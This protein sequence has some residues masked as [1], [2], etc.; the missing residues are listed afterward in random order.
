M[1]TSRKCQVKKW[2]SF[3][4]RALTIT[5]IF[6]LFHIAVWAQYYPAPKPISPDK[7][8]RLLLLLKNSSPDK[9]RVHLLLSL[10]NLNFNKPL[11][12]K[13]DIDRAM[14]FARDA[15]KLSSTLHDESGYNDAQL[16]IAD[17]FT[18]QDDMNSAENI[19]GLLNDTSKINL[20]LNL[21][22][23]YWLREVKVKDE[24]WKKALVFA[25]QARQ[26][27]VKLHLQEKEILAL[28]DM[29]MIHA[30]QGKA[31]A[32]SEYLEVIKKYKAINYPYL[33]Y[34]YAQLAQLNYYKGKPDKA[35]YY[36]MQTIKSMKSTGDSTVAG[37]FYLLRAIICLNNDE[38]QESYDFSLRAIN[39]YKV[40]AGEYSLA[41]R[42]IF[43]MIPRVLRKMKRYR[44]ALIYI[45]KAM[46]DYPSLTDADEIS[47]ASI[48]G[49]I[50]RDMKAY[51][52]A[53]KYFIQVLELSK[54]TGITSS[55]P[56][57]DI[58]QLYVESGQYEKAKPYLNKVL[59]FSKTEIMPSAALSHLHYM[60]FLT[61]SAT[62][63][64]KSAIQHISRFRGLEE[65]NLRLSK[66]KEVQKLEVEYGTKEK[67]SAIKIKDQNILLLKQSAKLQEAKLSQ[68]NLIKNITII[69]TLSLFVITGLL[70]KQYRNKQKTNK[71]IIQ[72]NE[73]MTQN[74]RVITQKNQVITQKNEQL[75]HLLQEK[76]WLIR[77]VHHRVKNNLH[78]V[79]C[80]LESQAAYLEEDALKAIEKS[81]NR[82]YAM[83]LIHQKL[84][85]SNDIN[86]IDMSSYIPELVQ[87]MKDIF[88]ISDQI[89]FH[90]NID[91]IGLNPSQAIPLAL[92][93]NEALTNSIKYAFPG[94][95][96]GEILISLRDCG[97]FL[98]LVLA[99]NGIGIDKNKEKIG[100][101]SLGLKLMKGLSKEI[102]GDIT[103]KNNHGVKITI[104]FKSDVPDYINNLQ[105]DF[106]TSA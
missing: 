34:V 62:G 11:K 79:I 67:E 78:T 86:T 41:D 65:Y 19:L 5:N 58:G 97:D 63:D 88:D 85:L 76:D 48:I 9:D 66:D 15:S 32:E 35:L 94:K 104:I 6:V 52:K 8:P 24:D 83:S 60:L 1:R 29:A 84:Y 80:L 7:E 73:M 90:M 61:D 81:Q 82:V 31:S 68:T 13:A 36:S 102:K 93:I 100:P 106:M 59:E 43:G 45:K 91:P 39:S 20:L 18:V 40:H 17:I 2:F 99:D 89:L 70:Y 23:K 21:S 57:K 74:N 16:F 33:H 75:E 77:E 28:K 71:V 10:C 98:K 3:S 101:V 53:E 14:R 64:Y 38:F 47:Y 25:E 105:S 103:I 96:Q 4:M 12:E 30:D 22:F 26:M 27:S 37:D 56:Y 92:I 50:Y 95:T 54:K 44:E 72:I 55:T 49:N 46:K 69:T 87:Y 42:R 51:D